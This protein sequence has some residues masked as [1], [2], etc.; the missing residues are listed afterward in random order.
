MTSQPSLEAF[1]RG[2]LLMV[3][4]ILLKRIG[5]E[6]PPCSPFRPLRER[7]EQLPSVVRDIVKSTLAM[8]KSTASTTE[9]T[10]HQM[11]IA[12]SFLL[13]LL[14][15][16]S[17]STRASDFGLPWIKHL[18]AKKLFEELYLKDIFESTLATIKH[19]LCE[20]AT[21]TQKLMSK[22]TLVVDLMYK[23][24]QL[25]ESIFMWKFELIT[26]IS[27][28]YANHIDS[29]ETPI[30]QPPAEWR[31][32]FLDEQL[33]HFIFYIY[34]QVRTINNDSIVHTSLQCLSQFSTLTGYVLNDAEKSLQFCTNLTTGMI[35][36]I[37]MNATTGYKMSPCEV[38]P[39]TQVLYRICLHIQDR[40]TLRNIEK[41]LMC[42]AL[43]LFTSF[44]CDI[45]KDAAATESNKFHSDDKDSYKQAV[46][47]LCDGWAI[48]LQARSKLS[49]TGSSSDAIDLSGCSGLISCRPWKTIQVIS[50][51]Y[52]SSSCSG[53]TNATS[54]QGFDASELLDLPLLKSCT[55][56]IFKTYL[57]CHLTRPQGF[58]E[59]IDD[60]DEIEEYE[61]D[62]LVAYNDQLHSIGLIGRVDL[63]SS[64]NFLSQMLIMR[65]NHLQVLMEK[66]ASC[67]K[68][69]VND[70][71]W[72]AVN[73]DIHW[74]IMITTW[75]LSESNWFSERDLI[76]DE[77]MKLSISASADI[78][79]TVAILTRLIS[80]SKGFEPVATDEESSRIDPVV[81]LILLVLK[82]SKL[83]VYIIENN[84]QLFSPQVSS[85]ISTFISHFMS[86]YLMPN[87]SD[88]SNLSMC[89]IT[90]F[91][92]DTPS[93]MLILEFLMEHML[94]K[95]FVWSTDA[96]V[97]E[98]TA[99]TLVSFVY[100]APDR[101]KY[102]AQSPQ[103]TKLLSLAGNNQLSVLSVASRKCIYQYLILLAGHKSSIFDEIFDP[104]MVK[105]TQI[106]STFNSVNDMTDQKAMSLVEWLECLIGIT[107]GTSSINITTVWF[108]FV[109]HIYLNELPT[110][111]NLCRNSPLVIE[112]LLEFM[113]AVS[114][115]LLCYLNRTES[116]KYY[117][118]TISALWVYTDHN[119]SR[120]TREV[121][122][123][124]ECYRDI[125]LMFQ[126]L[127]N[128]TSKDLLDWW[129]GD[130]AN[131]SKENNCEAA[132][133]S[134]ESTTT[135]SV[136][137]TQVIFVALGK[138]MPLLS[139]E[140]LEYPK[141][142]QAYYKLMS[143]LCDEMD[144][145]LTTDPS[146]IDPILQTVRFAIESK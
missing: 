23:L 112:A 26:I 62:D 77:V 32:I 122:A 140:L 13:A 28:Q 41:S 124:E 73:E 65:T 94:T 85:T 63:T 132:A 60:S 126:I 141:L 30:F 103:I 107:N 52:S 138:I 145:L 46:E 110:L 5:I 50:S 61:E 142:S 49:S 120:V 86:S 130:F 92:Q 69:S 101:A 88:Y 111:F 102:V 82:L 123:D 134:S 76:P 53:D 56:E 96:S 36:L 84:L 6:E 35:N 116:A 57:Q 10:T 42:Q 100:N 34:T 72:S 38:T 136:T 58:R 37:H 108:K 117:Q 1:V 67:G 105:Y 29:I 9:G 90:A 87:E 97:K 80:S 139:P 2:Q 14:N 64:I 27:S 20:N 71:E 129:N 4:A 113:N 104:L 114:N 133:S 81:M 18:D 22:D 33:A 91:G 66:I 68:Q 83:E 127:H 59:L 7:A 115:K 109:S 143:F 78:N 54:S 15:E 31:T 95:L 24:L 89:I 43:Q 8:Q 19:I 55:N 16:Y 125:L 17:S 51:K 11:H 75:T 79:L 121:S 45:M 137:A 39:L 44:T 146:L 106:R 47:N 93:S 128:L 119:K 144:T 74:L 98:S 70:A 48:I 21:L 135:P 118:A 12:T 25:L 131:D 3:A 40:D 99:Q